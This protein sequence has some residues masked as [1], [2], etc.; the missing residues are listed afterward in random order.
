MFKLVALLAF[1]AVASAAPGLVGAPIAY[2]APTVVAAAPV[3]YSAPVVTAP[4]VKAAV[5]V[6]TSYANTFRVV[7]PYSTSVVAAAPVVQAAPV[8]YAAGPVIKTLIH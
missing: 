4:V 2:S 7:S 1:V 8:A 5:P 3:A 6:A